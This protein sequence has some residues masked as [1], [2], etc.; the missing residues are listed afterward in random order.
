MLW[1]VYLS[2]VAGLPQ[3][4]YSCSC[5]PSCWAVRPDML[6]AHLSFF[7]A[8]MFDLP[9]SIFHRIPG[10]VTFDS[11]QG[12]VWQWALPRGAWELSHLINQSH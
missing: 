5:S 11:L 3:G 2:A 10:M 4:A 8:Q 9:P 7:Q 12:A 6:L 1:K